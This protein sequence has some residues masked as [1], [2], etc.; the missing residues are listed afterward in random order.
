MNAW[1]ATTL[2]IEDILG[3]ANEGHADILWPDG[4]KSFDAVDRVYPGM[5]I[6]SVRFAPVGAGSFILVAMLGQGSGLS[7]R[8]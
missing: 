5:R 4:N 2:D 8:A 1:Y 3:G 7:L 6:R